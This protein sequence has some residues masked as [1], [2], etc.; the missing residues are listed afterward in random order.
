[1]RHMSL[2]VSGHSHYLCLRLINLCLDATLLR[3]FGTSLGSFFCTTKLIIGHEVMRFP[4][5]WQQSFGGVVN[6][7]LNRLKIGVEE[8]L[9]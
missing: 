2:R 9:E 3:L 5:L 4:H 1:M 8:G 7:L 6:H